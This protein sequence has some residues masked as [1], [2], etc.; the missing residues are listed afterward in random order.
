MA[1]RTRIQGSDTSAIILPRY[2][3]HKKTAQFSETPN[4]FARMRETR[5]SKSL[6]GTSQTSNPTSYSCPLCVKWALLGS[7]GGKRFGGGGWPS[8]HGW[9]PQAQEVSHSARN[10]FENLR[11][12]SV[13]PPV[14]SRPS[15]AG[16]ATRLPRRESMAPGVPRHPSAPSDCYTTTFGSSGQA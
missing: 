4:S 5:P 10:P 9:V 3:K 13:R 12:L 8:R 6:N 7:H 1:S 14:A 11:T 16:W 15:R 2:Q